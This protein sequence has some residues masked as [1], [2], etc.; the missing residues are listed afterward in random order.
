L[1]G[2][3]IT[4]PLSLKDAASPTAEGITSLIA[5]AEAER[6]AQR[7]STFIPGLR[8]DLFELDFHIERLA[9]A[10]DRIREKHGLAVAREEEA[11]WRARAAR[12]RDKYPRL[13]AEIAD[14]LGRVAANDVEPRPC[15]RLVEHVARGLSPIDGLSITGGVRLL[16]LEPRAAEMGERFWPPMTERVLNVLPDAVVEAMKRTG[17]ESRCTTEAVIAAHAANAGKATKKLPA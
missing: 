15:L 7:P 2:A 12:G 13:A 10:F 17:E 6:S 14:L 1:A 3:T 8:G 11:A 9:V 4:Q 16:A 5:E